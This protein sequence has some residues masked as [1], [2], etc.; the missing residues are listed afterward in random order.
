[1]FS[2]QLPLYLFSTG[3]LCFFMAMSSP[4]MAQTITGTIIDARTN[5]PLAGANVLEVG[6]SNGVSADRSG[7]FTLEITGTEPVRLRITFVGYR[8]KTIEAGKDEA[9]LQIAMDRSTLM[10]NEVFVEALRADEASPMAYENVSHTRIEEKNLGQDLPYLLE[11]TPSVTTT[12]DAGGGIGYTGLRIRGVDQRRINVT[13]NGIPVNDAESHGVYWVNMPDLASSV[14]NIQ[15][16][17]GVGTSTNGAAAFGATMNIQTTQ[18]QTDPYGEVNTSVGSFNTRKAN[19]ML[20]SGL[21]NNGWQFQGRLSKIASDGYIDRASSDLKSFYL[22]AAR[23]GD[24]SLLRSDIFSGREKTYQAWY[25]VSES[26]LEDGDRTHNPAG[27]EKA[28][29]PYDNQTD[30]Y[31]QDHYQLHYSYQLSDSWNANLSAH[32]T[33]GRGYY[34]EYKAEQPL[35]EYNIAPIGLP[36]TTISQ[37]D[38]VRQLWLDNHFYG[39]VFSTDY[40]KEDR[41]SLTLGGGYNEYDGDHFGEVV[42]ARYAGDSEMDDRYYFNNAFKKD[43]NTYLKGRY[44]LTDHFTAFADAQIRQITYEFLGKDRL[45]QPGGGEEVVDVEQ[46]DELAFFN[47]KAGLTYRL[48]NNHRAYLS[49]SVG[50]KEPTRDEYVNS[51]PE[52]RPRH[53]TLYD[54]EAGY[55]GTFESFQVSANF[56][57]MDYKDQLILTGEINDVGAYVRQNVP[58]SYRMGIELQAGVQLLDNLEWSG[59]AT[60]SRNK[61]RDY[62]YYLDDYDS[63]TQDVITY[64]NSDIAFSPDVTAHSLLRY[65][66]EGLSAQ[67]SS[68]YV[69][70]QYLDNTQT[71]SRSLDPYFVNDVQLSYDWTAISLM[72]KVKA[73]LMVN[74]LFNVMY[75][76]NGYTYGFI[77]DGNPQYFNYYYPQAGRNFLLQLSFKF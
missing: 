20:G 61:I 36:D 68:K 73:T 49:F 23:N 5:E 71:R 77:A 53:E 58:E 66:R 40:K 6:T 14:E 42:W 38:L 35:G 26:R 64:E 34:E 28:G 47:P 30:N 27:T 60:F 1:M 13:I 4:L 3:I 10:S 69:A 22:S 62:T 16:Q 65:S 55:S 75:E 9:S 72:E 24:R 8:T 48:R 63:G 57:Y 17:R 70:R 74:N 59:N 44:H 2:K 54:W 19:V 41:W 25:G 32:Y 52:N 43:F 50:N 33:Y 11:G 21:M 7:R 29:E 76:S 56:Y 67:L 39:A 12:S 51:T 18:M 46:R 15:V 31:Q 37:S 45:R